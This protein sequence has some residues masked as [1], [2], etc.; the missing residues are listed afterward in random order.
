[1]ARQRAHPRRR[2]FDIVPVSS[3]H[4]G[5]EQRP[6]RPPLR[7]RWL[8]WLLAGIAFG[9][10]LRGSF[11]PLLA[12]QFKEVEAAQSS[13]PVVVTV[14]VPTTAPSDP[15]EPEPEVAESIR[16]VPVTVVVTPTAEPAAA[17]LLPMQTVAA[18]EVRPLVLAPRF[19]LRLWNVDDVAT[20]WINDR[21]VKAK[22]GHKGIEPNWQGHGH[23]PGDSGEIYITPFLREGENTI[24]FEIW[25][26][27]V[28]CGVSLSVELR[29]DNVVQ[30]FDSSAERDSSEGVKW[31]GAFVLVV[32]AGALGSD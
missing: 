17:T 28:C 8:Q 2:T 15:T 1:M 19:T 30:F 20:A 24:R 12:G 5:P 18:A 29:R 31:R 11:F 32:P 10:I 23:S 7:L 14:V 25:N 9:W 3:Q 6:P 13:Q 27:R 4:G 21:V 16:V 26:V 22:W